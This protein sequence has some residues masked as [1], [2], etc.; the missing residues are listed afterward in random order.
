[1]EKQRG[2]T[3]ITLTITIVVMMIIAGIT[4]YV[5]SDLIKEAKLQ[6]LRTNMLLIQ[7]KAKEYVEE[8]AFQTANMDETA[9]AEKIATIKSENYK[10]TPLSGSEA[11]SAA[12]ATNK[13][14]TSKM[15]EY[16]YLTESDLTRMGIEQLS[17]EEYGYF[18]VRYNLTD[19]K[20]EVIN[21]EGYQGNYTL[22]E[23]N[24][25]SGE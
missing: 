1:M 5:G 24:S 11:E 13:I 6:D 9:D 14:N 17:P 12:T 7:A 21:T 16:Y 23:L 20:I 18:I 10:G 8:V 3:L 22:E 4:V 19:I 25:L 15:D 2:V